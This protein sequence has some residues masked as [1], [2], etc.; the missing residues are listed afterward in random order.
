MAQPNQSERDKQREREKVKEV[1]NDPTGRILPISDKDA[2]AILE[3]ADYEEGEK[4]DGTIRNHMLQCR[5]TAQRANKPLLDMT[6]DDLDDLFA[7]MKS[8]RHPDVKENGITV[9]G[10]QSSL[11]VFY[12]YHDD[13]PVDPEEIELDSVEGRQLSA[14]DL[15]FE[16]EVE[17]LLNACRRQNPRDLAMIALMLATGQRLDAVRTLRLKDVRV[18]GP[19]MEVQLN[20]DD[21]ALKGASGAKPLLWA[22]HYVR[23][24]YEAHP[25]KDNPN[26]ALFCVREEPGNG[27]DAEQAQEPMEDDTVRRMVRRRADDAGLEKRVYPHLFR[28]TAITRMVIEGLSEQKIKQIAGWNPDSSQFGTYV[29]LA[30]NLTTDSVRSELGLPTS[31]TGTPNLGAPPLD[32]C[33]ECHDEIPEGKE[34][35]PTCQ[36]PLT[37]SEAERGRPENPEGEKV[38]G[39]YQEA[40]DMGTVE[41]IQ[42]LDELLNDPEVKQLMKQR[43]DDE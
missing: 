6:N 20:T 25:H 13:T 19:T 33:P 4:A 28:H 34:R 32:T 11:R 41:K 2:D 42:A 18:D 38:R 35:C 23:P 24:W 16:D 14:D 3:L 9:R 12:K 31:D 30:D 17:E 39:A 10:Y 26:A 21:G 40:D 22:K 27:I 36:T 7:A 8:G 29:H 5:K 15:L 37:H 43:M 1:A